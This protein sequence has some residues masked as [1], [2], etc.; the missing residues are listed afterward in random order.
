LDEAAWTGGGEIEEDERVAG[1]RRNHEGSI[2]G[3]VERDKG[4]VG[5]MCEVDINISP[6][7]RSPGKEVSYELKCSHR[8]S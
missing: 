5:P 6:W 1:R 3:W 8:P 4:G 7:L 2:F